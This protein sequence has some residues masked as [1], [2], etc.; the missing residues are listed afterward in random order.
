MIG[1]RKKALHVVIANRAGDEAL[2]HGPGNTEPSQLTARRCIEDRII[3]LLI[4]A[5]KTV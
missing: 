3:S 2:A 4:S 1:L 5:R